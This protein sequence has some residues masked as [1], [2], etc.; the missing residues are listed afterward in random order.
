[1]LLN[2]SFLYRFSIAVVLIPPPTPFS[3]VSPLPPAPTVN[4]HTIILLPSPWSLIHVLCLVPS[5]SFYNYPLLSSHRVTFSVFEHVLCFL[6][7]MP[8]S[9][10]AESNGSLY[11]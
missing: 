11:V 1:M 4:S 8:E 5:P 2:F 7:H 10:I 9:G 6:G 3:P